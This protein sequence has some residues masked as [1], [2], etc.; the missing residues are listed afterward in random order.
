MAGKE[1]GVGKSVGTHARAIGKAA[2]TGDSGTGR[3]LRGAGTS[4]DGRVRGHGQKP[5]QGAAWAT[6]RTKAGARHDRRARA[7]AWP[8]GIEARASRARGYDL[9]CCHTPES[10]PK[11]TPV[12]SPGPEGPAEV[13]P[14]LGTSPAEGPAKARQGGAANNTSTGRLWNGRQYSIYRL[15]QSNAVPADMRNNTP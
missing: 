5:D 4:T 9:A 15:T 11:S 12:T 6:I 1:Q 8:V 2:R 7:G 14:L 3:G 10:L 13:R